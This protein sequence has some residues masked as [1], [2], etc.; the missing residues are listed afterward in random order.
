MTIDR[1]VLIA[2]LG[3]SIISDFS[4]LFRLDMRRL[5]EKFDSDS[6]IVKL[7]CLNFLLVFFLDWSLFCSPQQQMTFLLFF[8]YHPKIGHYSKLMKVVPKISAFFSSRSTSF[9]FFLREK[10]SASLKT[11]SIGFRKMNVVKGIAIK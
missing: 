9:I 3:L 2:F 10:V 1:S 4:T 5:W 7:I 11:S 8:C 6:S